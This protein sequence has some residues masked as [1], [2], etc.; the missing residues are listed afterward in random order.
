MP[1]A[2]NNAPWKIA[3][4]RYFVNS[5]GNDVVLRLL[6]NRWHTSD[7]LASCPSMSHFQFCSWRLLMEYGYMACSTEI[8]SGVALHASPTTLAQSTCENGCPKVPFVPSWMVSRTLLGATLQWTFYRG[9]LRISLEIPQ[10]QHM[11]KTMCLVKGEVISPWWTVLV[12]PCLVLLVR[13]LLQHMSPH[14]Y[15]S[16]W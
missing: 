13:K 7:N 11:H 14:L 2:V 9:I 12:R 1:W 6:E 4:K 5:R 3:R 16:C 15:F 8:L 10:L